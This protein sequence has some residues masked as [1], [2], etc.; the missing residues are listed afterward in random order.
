MPNS[1]SS[2]QHTPKKQNAPGQ[3]ASEEQIGV[4]H[5]TKKQKS[6]AL[7]SPSTWQAVR[8]KVTWEEPMR[9]GQ[10]EPGQHGTSK[11]LALH[12]RRAQQWQSAVQAGSASPGNIVQASTDGSNDVPSHSSGGSINPS[13]QTGA[14][15]PHWFGTPPPPHVCPAGHTPHEPPQPSSPQVLFAQLGVQPHTLGVPPPPQV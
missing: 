2:T 11:K 7:Q 12:A 15:V 5:S 10:T 6:P 14:V 13:P 3:S 9:K 8:Q 4:R 1:P